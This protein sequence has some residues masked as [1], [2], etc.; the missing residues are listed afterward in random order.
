MEKADRTFASVRRHRRIGD[1][2]LPIAFFIIVSVVMT[3]WIAAIGWAIWCLI[4][5]I[6]T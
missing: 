4:A 1:L 3:A 2:L 5:W 6:L